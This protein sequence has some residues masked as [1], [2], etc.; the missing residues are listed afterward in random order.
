MRKGAMLAVLLVALAGCSDRD[1]GNG[2]DAPADAALSND[3]AAAAAPAAAA[4]PVP[5]PDSACAAQTGVAATVCADPMLARMDGEVARLFGLVRSGQDATPD[6]QPALDQA[7]RTWT[8]ERDRCGEDAAAKPC[9]V[10]SYAARID[11]L[12]SN[13]ADAR[14]APDPSDGPPASNGPFA[15][16][17]KG[18]DEPIHALFVNVDPDIVRLRL[19]QEVLILT[20]APAASGV[21]YEGEGGGGHYVFWT[22][23]AT[24]RFTQPGKRESRCTMEPEHAASASG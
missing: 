7:Q 15:V 5:P 9:L 12:R 2:A 11:E 10:A 18:V 20:Q 16:H 14:A 3:T 21:R 23:G 13:Y 19:D 6:M 22:K 8:N 24:A 1:A 17:C 4:I